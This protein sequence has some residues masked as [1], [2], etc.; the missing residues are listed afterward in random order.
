[1]YK[2]AVFRIQLR[3]YLSL[4]SYF[5][6]LFRLQIYGTLVEFETKKVN[7]DMKYSYPS[8]TRLQ[9][10]RRTLVSMSRVTTKYI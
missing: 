3:A 10:M 6:F 2:H 8:S 5:R 9:R 4:L 7:M 1:M